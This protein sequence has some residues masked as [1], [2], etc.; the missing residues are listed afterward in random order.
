MATTLHYIFDPFCGWCYAV[1]PLVEAAEQLPDLAIELHAGGMLSG[2]RRRSITPQWREYVLPHDRRIAQMS[3]QPFGEAYF[4][5]LLRDTT[6]VLDSTPPII[7]ILAAQQL[8]GQGLRMLH[9]IQHAHYVEGRRV[10]DESVL[11]ALAE[12]IGLE[13]DAFATAYAQSAGQPADEHIAASRS[14]LA[15]VGGDGFPTFVWDR[16]GEDLVLLD[17]SSFLGQPQI[18]AAQ[19]SGLLAR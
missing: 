18:W 14:L 17:G 15:R 1:A 2:Y 8:S 4:N 13:R 6:A 3:G 12:E 16:S 19:L 11:Q 9:R 5:G 10:A 7:A